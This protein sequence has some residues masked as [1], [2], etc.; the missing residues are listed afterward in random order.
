MSEKQEFISVTI[1][2]N[3]IIG[4]IPMRDEN[5]VTIVT[6]DGSHFMRAEK[7]MKAG[8]QEGTYCLLLPK[9]ENYK[10]RVTRESGNDEYLNPRQLKAL[11]EGSLQKQ[12]EKKPHFVTISFKKS[13]VVATFEKDGQDYSRIITPNGYTFVRSSSQIKDSF[14]DPGMCYLSLP[15]TIQKDGVWEEY[16]IVLSK[17]KKKEGITEQTP[18]DERYE[19]ISRTVTVRELK[20]FIEK[21][22]LPPKH[23]K[24]EFVTFEITKTQIVDVFSSKLKSEDNTS[25]N[26]NDMLYRIMAT[27]GFS[28]L[29][30]V[31]QVKP[32]I[33]NGSVQTNRF[34]FCLPADYQIKLTKSYKDMA[35]NE[36][37]KVERVIT[38]KELK[39]HITPKKNLEQ[40]INQSMK[41]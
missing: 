10:I 18:K 1:D 32:V 39:E 28:F 40:Q 15:E 20:S 6:P 30:P 31:N 19:S 34:Q 24:E 3:Q 5:Y 33:E 11:C 4:E 7:Q 8:E 12:K 21:G 9:D 27:E 37:K 25:A 16:R 14:Q 17:S 23:E 22:Y 13:R 38:A 41:R 35:T 26:Q 36:Y 2:K 29:R